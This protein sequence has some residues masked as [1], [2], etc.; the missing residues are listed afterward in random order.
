VTP[1]WTTACPD[2]ESRIVKRQ[3]LVP[4]APLFPAE[5]DAALKIM[6]SLRIV[7]AAGSPMIGD[8]CLQWVFDFAGAVFGSYDAD[9]GRRL[10]RNYFQLIAKKNSKSTSAAA[11]MLTALLRNWRKS[12]EFLIVAPTIEVANN[13]FNP[14]QD[15]VRA[16]DD[17][18]KLLHVQ[19][20]IRTITHRV[21][22][23]TL[24]VI[25]ADN[26][27]VSGKKA[28]GV[29]IDELWLF[30]KRMNAEN[31]LREA[32]GG[33]ASRP[34][35]FVIYLS[36]Q[37]DEPPAGIFAQKL[38]EARDIRDGIVIDP[39]TLGVL[40]EYPKYMLDDRS[41]L[42]PKNFYIPNPN[43]GASVDNEF[44]V[45][46]FEKAQRA[47]PQSLCGFAAK[48]L[49]VEIGLN[50]RSD[51][52]AGADFWE[53]C[54]DHIVTLDYLISRSE[55]AVVGIDGG[56]LDDM[57][58]LA[59]IGRDRVTREWLLYTHGWVHE[60]VL[61][62]RKDMASTIMD[63]VQD[64]DV[65]I[66]EQVGEDV[67]EVADI[68]ERL[69]AVRLLP[70]KHAIG[71]DQ[72]GIGAIVE[73]IVHRG[74]G[75]ERIIGIPQG[76][77]LMGSIKTMERMLAAGEIV[78]SAS[79]FM[80]WTVSNAKVEARGNAIIITKQAAG[81]AKIDALMAAFDAVA[82]MGQ[83]PQAA[84]SIYETRELLVL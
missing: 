44:L 6:R 25:A 46:E 40:Y 33:L 65:T 52:W 82:V 8:A 62:L 16:D 2:W 43:L 64:G 21:T 67:K 23:A 68:V 74:V 38:K 79:R 36:T 26:E 10:I 37:S 54:G 14:A 60:R 55:M 42:D 75:M 39:K 11:I 45:D 51:R 9:S 66:V 83:N 48:H 28:V 53:Q 84:Q 35:G 49:N 56:G 59:V 1:I 19:P 27:T 57:L 76:Y 41:F 30:G 77:K 18:A 22:G 4:F 20:N 50:L 32:T 12:A 13:S 47:G 71:V 70:K 72:S 3:S 81:N 78:H 63:F 58:G 31:M 24:K 73:G 15:M 17:L 7:D 61:T 5:A 69:E 29:L 80:A 34:E